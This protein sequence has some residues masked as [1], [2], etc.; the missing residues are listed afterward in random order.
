MIRDFTFSKNNVCNFNFQCSM[1]TR[2][3]KNVKWSGKTVYR[4]LHF[5]QH[6]LVYF[7]VF[8]TFHYKTT[9]TVKHLISIILYVV[10]TWFG[11]V[12]LHVISNSKDVRHDDVIKWKQMETFSVTGHLCEEFLGHRCAHQKEG[13][14]WGDFYGFMVY[15]KLYFYSFRIVF[16]IVLYRTTLIESL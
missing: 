10:L 6:R 2:Y 11:Q 15:T 12:Q 14:V 8:P 9:F 7:S 16:N 3:G 5:V 13:E 1:W 4:L